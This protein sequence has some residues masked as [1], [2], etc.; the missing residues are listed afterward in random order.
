[1]QRF[2]NLVASVGLVLYPVVIYLGMRHEA[3]RW[4]SLLAIALIAPALYVRFRGQPLEKLSMFAWIPLLTVSLLAA[5]ALLNSHGM[6]L[7]APVAVNALLLVGF[8]ATLWTDTSMIERFARLETDQLSEAQQAW[9]RAW[10]IVWCVFFVANGAVAAVLAA[11]SPLAWW[12]L[13]NSLIAYVLIGLLFGIERTARW[14][15]FERRP[16]SG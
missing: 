6:V 15:R 5:G 3:L 2:V 14:F 12:G 1:M 7:T 4:A 13:Y 9:C 16:D 8:G 10:T 11:C